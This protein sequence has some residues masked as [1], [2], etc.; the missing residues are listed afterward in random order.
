MCNL[1]SKHPRRLKFDIKARVN[2]TKRNLDKN[3]PYPT[4]LN[5]NSSQAKADPGLA[6][7]MF[8]SYF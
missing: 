7:A 2:Q 3:G 5:P 4:P 6:P 8:A 1:S